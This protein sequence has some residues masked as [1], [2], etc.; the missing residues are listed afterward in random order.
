MKRSG[1]VA[2]SMPSRAYL[3]NAVGR[4][5]AIKHCISQIIK[6]ERGKE[7]KRNAHKWKKLAIEVVDEGGS[8]DNK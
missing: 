5:E 8:S 6:G 1:R 2:L 7:I 3:M 4:Q